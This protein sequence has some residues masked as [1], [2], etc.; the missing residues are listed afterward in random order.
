MVEPASCTT[1]QLC[2]RPRLCLEGRE[3]ELPGRQGRLIF[4]FLVVNRR[5]AVA[6]DELLDL[7]WPVDAPDDPGDVL[8]ALLSRVRRALG[9]GVLAGRRELALLLPEDTRVDVEDARDAAERAE[10]ALA[11]AD[12]AEAWEAA[13]EAQRIAVR[14]F[15][16]GDDAPWVTERRSEVEQLHLRSLEALAAAGIELGGAELSG[17]ARAAR[18]AVEAAPFAESAHRL[19]MEALAGHGDVAEALRVYEQLRI[20]LRDE[21]GTAPGPAIQALHRRLLGIE[22]DEGPPA[23]S[24]TPEQAPA[25]PAE[26]PGDERKPV[27]I[28]CTEPA[29]PGDP[30][31]PE[32]LRS[33]LDEVGGRLRTVVERFG[34]VVYDPAATTAVF[35][36][37]VAHEDDAERAIRAALVMCERGTVRR[38]AVASGEAIV[39]GAARSATGR[40]MATAREM[41][42]GAPCG[43]VAVDEDTARAA[44]SSVAFEVGDGCLIVRNLRQRSRRATTATPL[45]G[46]ARELAAL[47]QLHGTAVDREA[48]ML[49]T[50]AGQAGVGKSRLAEEFAGHAEAAGSIVFRG[51][52]LPYGDGIAFW[53]L[54]EILYEAAE[55]ALD[56]DARTARGKLRALVGR[57]GLDDAATVALAASAGISMHDQQHDGA[58]PTDVADEIALAWPRFLSARAK[59]APVVAVIEDL[60]W[61]DPALLATLEHIVAR[62]QGPLMLLTT[63]RPEFAEGNPSWGHRARRSQ[64]ALDALS[65]GHSRELVDAVLP[66]ASAQLRER[67]AELAEGNPFFAEE[68]ARHLETGADPEAS[69]PHGVRALLAARIDALPPPEKTALQ[70]AAVVGRRFWLSALEPNQ[71]GKSLSALMASLEDRGLVVARPESALPGEREFWFAHGLTR[72]VAYR[73]IPRGARCRTHAAVGAWIE[74]LAGDR[75]EEFIALLAHHY[76]AAAS[77]RHAEQAWRDDPEAFE[78][79]RAAAV[80]ALLD[81][82]S[83]ARRGLVSEDASGLAD[84]ALALVRDDRERLAALELRARAFHAA[85]RGDEALA[86][87]LEALDLATAL[88]DHRAVA[89]LR[90]H[91]VLLCTRYMGAFSDDSWAPTARALVERGLAATPQDADS[92]ELGALLLGRSWGRS[93]WRDTTQRDLPAARHDVERVLVIAERIGSNYLLAHALEG[94]TWLALEQGYCEAEAMGDRLQRAGDLLSNRTEGHESLGV[95]AICFARAGRFERARLAAAEATRQ[96]VHLSPHRALHAGAA[97]VVALAPA[98]RFGE[99]LGATERVVGL[100][101]GEGDRVCATGLLALAGRVLALYEAEEEP[102]AERALA[103]LRRL[104]PVAGAFRTFGHPAAELLRPVLGATATRRFIDEAEWRGEPG[105]AISRLRATLPVLALAGDAAELRGAIDEARALAGPACAPAL[106]WIADMA[107]AALWAREGDIEHATA[108]AEAAAA[109]LDRHGERYTAARLAAELLPS[110]GGPQ[111]A[112][113][114]RRTAARLSSMGAL[115]SARLVTSSVPREAT[116]AS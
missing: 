48:P 85:V 62:S 94:M 23:S 15:L 82:G 38:A 59:V 49:V 7:L 6:R 19:L 50:L 96:A 116:N 51:R 99:L 78:R 39:S 44:R 45:V 97:E 102:Q 33:A 68:I 3:V 27:T 70:H 5:R 91:A 53:P 26:P 98:G 43:R 103:L 114:G 93:R 2:G 69:I 14:G 8:S 86:A 79:V 110:V 108:H 55:I 101:E 88:G 16:V 90:A 60:H 75:R 42:A 37:A 92:F 66:R 21:L 73:S 52:C 22:P 89:R 81:A 112:G 25:G 63:A 31:D 35:G 77:L 34:G 4:A 61:A 72:E 65:K 9:S 24:P 18:E 56:D 29:P 41:L 1:I 13:R 10:T 111:A 76:E 87:Y 67:V 40:C 12:W 57:L 100:A 64:I 20:L 83:A 46:R 30:A 84:R 54:R 17:A 71:T 47:A 107:E 113:L 58:S 105:D 95:A 11:R 109:A 28:L 74:R 104:A 32:E 80:R 106:A 36:A 115:A